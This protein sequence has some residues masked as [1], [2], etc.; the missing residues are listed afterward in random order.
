MD[1]GLI[2]SYIIAGILL[3]SMLMMNI[4]V[5]QNSAE[6]TL[7]QITREKADAIADMIYDD[8]P[9]MGY[10]NDGKTAQIITEADSSKISFYRKIDPSNSDPAELVTWEFTD[11][12]VNETENPNDRVLTRTVGGDVTEIKLGVTDFEIWYF[13]D[14]GLSTIPEDNEYLAR[15]VAATNLSDIKQIYIALELESAEQIYTG[16]GGTGRYIQTAW[17]KRYSPGN[18]E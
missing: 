14:F 7:T 8:I 3:I 5:N 18:I 12:P 17:E 6:I 1:A 13:D 9:N 10:D 2:T 16:P 11:T 4:R 15:P